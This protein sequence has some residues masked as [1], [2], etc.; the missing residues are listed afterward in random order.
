MERMGYCL[1]RALVVIE[2]DLIV[3]KVRTE[4]RRAGLS[5]E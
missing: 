5:S 2:L 1:W 3:A 4:E